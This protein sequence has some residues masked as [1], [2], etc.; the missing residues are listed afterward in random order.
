MKTTQT[1]LIHLSRNIRILFTLV[2][3]ALAQPAWAVPQEGTPDL[4]EGLTAFQ[5]VLY[6]VLAPLG[7]FLA[8]VVLGYA[9]HRPRDGKQKSRSALTEIR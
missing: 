8:I 3:V 2:F 1:H 7:L 9:V 5:T 6:F 4:V